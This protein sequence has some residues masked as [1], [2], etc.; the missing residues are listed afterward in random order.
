MGELFEKLDMYGES[1]YYPYHMPG[2]KRRLNGELPKDWIKVDITEIDGFDNLHQSEG[3]LLEAQKRAA[4]LFQAKESFFLINGSTAGILSAISAVLP[5]GGSL[6]MARSC[7]KSVYHAAYLRQLFIVY[8]YPEKNE[9][10]DIYEPISP[11]QVEKALNEN[12]QCKAVLIVSPTY[13]G[14]IGNIAR[15][16][17][18]V[19]ER[20]GVLIVDEAH[21]AHLGLADG[22]SKNSNQAG[23]DLVIQ[24]VHKTLPALTQSAIL[25]VNSDRIDIEKLKRFLHIYQSS[26]P[27]YLLM[28]GIENA[29]KIIEKDGGNLFFNFK[30]CYAEM[31]S[32][33]SK[34]EKLRVVT[35]AVPKN[36][37]A[38]DDND[39]CIAQDIGKLVIDTSKTN[40]SGQKLYQIL[41]DQY[42][43]QVEMAGRNYCLAMFTIGDTQEGYERMTKALLEIDGTLSKKALDNQTVKEEKDRVSESG[44]NP[45]KGA[46]SLFKAWDMETKNIRMEE[47]VGERTAEF[48]NLYPPGIPILVPGEIM[49]EEILSDIE[50]CLSQG[51]NVQGIEKRESSYFVKCIV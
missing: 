28:S 13:E 23:A 35:E 11:K 42:H 10:F 17:E 24:S 15:I 51:M 5:V 47:S 30:K 43:L 39:G 7:H 40:I 44:R 48:V 46:I 21:G 25:H 32:R 33:L 9:S 41:L 4:A 31:V 27:S 26:S 20:G 19:H 49:T 38:F 29:M 18:I 50:N 1:D 8:L 3:I 36:H 16:A 2:H 12:P 6:L 34:C 45:S 22:F 14:R 37:Y